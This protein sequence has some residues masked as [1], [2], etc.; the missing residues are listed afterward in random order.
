[1][2]RDS[3]IYLDDMLDAAR[4]I[5]KYVTGM[6]FDDFNADEKTIDAMIRN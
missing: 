5:R 6:D 2:P 1:M 4:K 3:R